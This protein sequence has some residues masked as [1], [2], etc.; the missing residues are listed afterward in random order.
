ME[1]NKVE[2]RLKIKVYKCHPG[3]NSSDEE[4]DIGS[5]EYV[6]NLTKAACLTHPECCISETLL[7]A[8]KRYENQKEEKV[9]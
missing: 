1:K 3:Q 2:G 9:Y 7:R 5:A 8:I 4:P 6:I